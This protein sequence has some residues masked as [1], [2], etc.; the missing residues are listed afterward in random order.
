MRVVSPVRFFDERMLE[1]ARWVRERYVAPLAA[2]LD[3]LSP[4]R[5]AG[6]EQ[7]GTADEVPGGFRGASGAG[8]R[9]APGLLRWRSG[10]CWRPCVVGRARSRSVRRP[11]TR[12]PSPSRRSPPASQA[13]GAPSCWSPRP[14]RARPRPPPSSR[15]SAIAACCSLGGDRRARYRTWLR[16][17]AR[18]RSTSSSARARRCTRR[19]TDLGLLYVSRESHPAHREDRSPAYHVRDV[20]LERARL[21][22]RGG[23][24]RGARCPIVRGRRRSS[25]PTV[26]APRDRW[27]RVE[28]VRPGHRGTGAPAGRGPADGDGAG[29]CS[30]RSAGYGVAQVC[31][32]CGAPARLCRVRRRA[33][34]RGG[35]GPVRGVR[36]PGRCAHCGS[37]IFGIRRGGAERVVEWASSVAASVPVREVSRP[38]LPKAREIL[39]GG[40]EDVRDLGPGGLDLVAILDADVATGVR[41]GSTAR[42]RALA[43]WM[44]AV[45]WARRTGRAIVQ[46]TR[47]RRRGDPGARPGQRRPVPR[48]RARAA[49]RV[50][51][52]GG[53]G[54]LPG[55]RG[56]R[57]SSTRSGPR[58]P[59]TRL[60]SA[61]GGRTVCLLALEPGAVPS[62]RRRDA[63]ARRSRR[64]RSGRGRAAPVNR[65]NRDAPAHPHARRPGAAR[66]R[67]SPS[68]RST[69]R[70]APWPRTCSRRCTRRRASGWRARRSGIGLRLFVFDDGET[71]PL[72]HGEPR[73]ERGRRA[74]SSRRRGASSIPGPYHA[75][76]R[77]AASGA[78][79]FDV[80]GAP[81]EMVGEGLLARIFQHET[82]HLDGRLYIDRLD[83]EG[84]K[85]VLAELRRIELGLAEPR[86]RERLTRPG[87]LPRERPLVGPGARGARRRSAVE[88]VV[89]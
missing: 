29:S 55:D 77:A 43:T 32:A 69:G 17:R 82:D 73:A 75:T 63:R 26:S 67:R 37:S 80:R 4:P 88:V 7:H 20:A 12:P 87:R 15:R 9:R 11:R 61:L 25:S 19:S 18:V 22:G 51:L 35:T 59:I 62:L 47:A 8:C 52:P 79:G 41:P 54:G 2:V 49:G 60:V 30:P 74:R 46:A 44:E 65:R 57:G 23:D 53:R 3:R 33:A 72:V 66:S 84:R 24:P 28:V 45:G 58:P 5:V 70:S 39:V 34:R 68:P 13:A 27:P 42:E 14:R 40:P 85:A 78:R 36:G 83:E 64:R 76:Q 50:G 81:V 21:G 86:R 38:R 89:A 10:I 6:E 16:D 48:A 71:G 31:R 1:L 56:R